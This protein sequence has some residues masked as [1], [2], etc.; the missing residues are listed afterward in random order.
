MATLLP[1]TS[2]TVEHNETTYSSE[3]Q[4]EKDLMELLGETQYE[5]AATPSSFMDSEFEERI[6]F[7]WTVEVCLNVN[8]NSYDRPHC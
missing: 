4:L 2:P 8:T 1:N 7:P 5:Q 6:L 3:T